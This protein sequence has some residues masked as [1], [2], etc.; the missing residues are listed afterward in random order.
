MISFRQLL[1][2]I[3]VIAGVWL[4]RHL[5]KRLTDNPWRQTKKNQINY[6]DTVRCELCGTHIPQSMALGDARQGYRCDDAKH[7]SQRGHAN[8]SHTG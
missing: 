8:Q 7:C 5:Q 4:F 6:Q 1:I 3:L 2:I